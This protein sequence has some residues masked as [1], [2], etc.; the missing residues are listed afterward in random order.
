[1]DFRNSF[2]STL[3]SI[4]DSDFEEKALALFRYQSTENKVYKAY[5][6]ALGIDVAAV[7]TIEQIPFLPIEFFKEHKVVSTHT[8]QGVVF[9]SSGTTGQVTS[10][11]YVAD[12]EWY[13]KVAEQIFTSYYGNFDDY[14]LFGLLPSYLERANSSLVYM[15]NDFI[16]K[17][18]DSLSGFFLNEYKTLLTALAK[19]KDSGKRVIVFGATFGLLDFM[20]Q[21]NPDLSDCLVVETGGMKGRREELTREELHNRFRSLSGVDTINA[22]YGMTELLSQA[23][24]LDGTVF[25]A[26]A[27]M[28]VLLRDSNDP[29]QLGEQ[30]GGINI[31]DLA[32]VDSCAFI[33]TSDIGERTDTGFKV[34]GRMD[35]SDLRGCSLLTV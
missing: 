11:H 29:F 21:C 2:K 33:E 28:K 18:N 3:F 23:Y 20:E 34:L 12:P 4:S 7:N 19:A 9:E 14:V 31:I 6:D 32:N 26:P 13:L 5:I 8:E 17:S 25:Q 22:E 30:K 35:N 24:A 16:K 1:M 10:K 27:W 15:V